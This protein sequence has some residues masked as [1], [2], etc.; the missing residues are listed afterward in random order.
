MSFAH[1]I[2]LVAVALLLVLAPSL[3]AADTAFLFTYFT[4]NGADGLHLAWSDDGYRWTVLDR[5]RS[6]LTPT[7][8]KDRLMR[9]PCVARGPDG[10]YHLVWTSGWWDHH[11]GYAS[12][13]D[14][15]NW[16]EQKAIPVMVHEPGVRNSWA[17][18]VVWDAQRAQ[19]LIFWASTIP[20]RFPETEG[21][22][23]DALNHRIYATTTKDWETFAPTRLF[24]EPGFNVIDATLLA[25]RDGGW[26]MIAKDETQ[27]PPKKHLRL[28]HATDVEGPWREFGAPFTRDWV[29][30][31]TAIRV[32]EDVLVYFD[33]YRERH[34]GALR[35]HDLKTWE[36]VTG[37]ISLPPGARHGTMIEVPRAL[38][39][40]LIEAKPDVE[41]LP[42]ST[43]GRP[44]SR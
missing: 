14:F 39:E 4:G 19:F 20:G 2:R 13:R 29:E 1:L 30:G 38:I 5:G 27:K 6:F 23:E 10:T 37:K 9:D 12:T 25:A 44:I 26:W 34:Y 18:E 15:L 32:G 28:A 24:V 11:I 43:P 41:A 3:R 35:S 17:P 8:G 40:R 16:S 36:D 33:V 31:P 7:V 21:S 22:S 42:S